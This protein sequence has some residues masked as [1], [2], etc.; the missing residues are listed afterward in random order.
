M[1]CSVCKEKVEDDEGICIG[2]IYPTVILCSMNC[3]DEVM[4]SM[5]NADTLKL[6][7]K[8]EKGE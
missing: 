5:W 6:K 2:V 4:D 1:Y 7:Y 3:Y 8:E